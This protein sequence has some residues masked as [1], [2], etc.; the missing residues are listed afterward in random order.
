MC[1]FG[2]LCRRQFP[3]MPTGTP[4]LPSW[5]L[6]NNSGDANSNNKS[7]SSSEEAT[8]EITLSSNP[9]PENLVIQDPEP[10]D[11]DE[12]E[13]NLSKEKSE[14]NTENKNIQNSDLDIEESGNEN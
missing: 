11:L 1:Y 8:N 2:F 5:Q 9:A 4:V 12:T 3:S 14:I 6:A 7:K 13:T 10:A